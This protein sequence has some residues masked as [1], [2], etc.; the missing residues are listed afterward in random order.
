MDIFP[1]S[2]E[3]REKD[4]LWLFDLTLLLKAV[5]GA[6]EMLGSA[7]ILIVPP[8]LVL[9]IVEFLTG[10]ELAQ[11]PDDPIIG[12]I[13]DAAQ[14]FSVHTHYFLA[15]YLFLH[16]VVKVALVIGIFKGKRIAYPLFMIALVIFGSYELYRG[17]VRHEMLVLALGV[18]DLL[19]LVLTIHEYRRRCSTP[20]FSRDTREDCAVL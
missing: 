7:L 17:F 4:I 11:D 18:F 14:S 16:G 20:L 1:A 2:A 5:N 15:V 3:E 10:G 6:F 19:V 12:A 8:T 9:K 13:R